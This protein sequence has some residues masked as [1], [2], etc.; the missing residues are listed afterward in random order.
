MLI[1][2]FLDN[3]RKLYCVF[4]TVQKR[5]SDEMCHMKLSSKFFINVNKSLLIMSII[6]Q[7]D[8][9]FLRNKHMNFGS[10]SKTR[11]NILFINVN[12]FLRKMSDIFQEHLALLRKKLMSL[13]SCF[14]H[15]WVF[16]RPAHPLNIEQIYAYCRAILTGRTVEVCWCVHSGFRSKARF[17]NCLPG[18]TRWRLGHKLISRVPPSKPAFWLLR[19]R[20][21]P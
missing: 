21:C 8:S 13:G 11:Q 19:V 15:R 7:E 20:G 16:I 6:F 3:D 9:A 1:T 12:K 18:H 4:K 10:N 2:N 14:L 17:L 5:M